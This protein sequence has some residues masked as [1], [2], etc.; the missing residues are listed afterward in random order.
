MVWLADI[1]AVE[2]RVAQLSGD[3]LPAASSP[4][5]GSAFAAL[6]RSPA[7]DAPVIATPF[8]ETGPCVVPQ[9]ALERII[10]GACAAN[11]TDPALVKAVVANESGF[12]AS[13]TSSAGAAGLMQLMPETAAGLGVSDRYDP[14]QNVAGGTKY[15][16]G[17]L[18]RFGGDVSL[19]LAAYNAGPEAVRRGEIGPETADYVRSVLAS[20]AE[21]RAANRLG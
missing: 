17:L 5:A 13:A 10:A 1:A 20:Y 19:A 21:Y 3:G 2:Y 9:P 8:A 7:A 12:D 14:K 15:L 16:Q 6:L 4:S 11:G 18:Q